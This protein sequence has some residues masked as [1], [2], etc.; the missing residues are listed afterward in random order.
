MEPY[1]S[2]QIKALDPLDLGRKG[3]GRVGFLLIQS[4]AKPML[5]E[6]YHSKPSQTA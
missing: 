3:W 2:H 4:Q 1:L 5:T 6:A